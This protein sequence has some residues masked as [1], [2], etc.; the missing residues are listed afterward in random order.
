MKKIISHNQIDDSCSRKARKCLN[1]VPLFITVMLAMLGLCNL[2]VL[3]IYHHNVSANREQIETKNEKKT[4]KSKASVKYA[5]YLDT[6]SAGERSAAERAYSDY[7]NKWTNKRENKA[8][9]EKAQKAAYKKAKNAVKS[10]KKNKSDSNSGG[11]SSNGTS[12]SSGIP[13]PSSSSSSTSSNSTK[14]DKEDDPGTNEAASTGSSGSAT[15]SKCGSV[16]TFFKWGCDSGTNDE[17]IVTTV[18][19][20]ILKWMAAGVGAAC[21]IGILVSAF[22]YVTAKDNASQARQ[23]VTGLKYAIGALIVFAAAGTILNFLIPGG[24]N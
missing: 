21:M 22:L 1:F 7:M 11:G 14:S 4:N 10:Y 19:K 15:G 9:S 3:A 12:S 24:L 6:L 20:S 13:N 8:I 5:K 23:A 18:V 17:D 2:N 16:N